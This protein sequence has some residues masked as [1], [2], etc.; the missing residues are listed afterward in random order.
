LHENVQSI[1]AISDVLIS[2]EQNDQTLEHQQLIVL[3]DKCQEIYHQ[4][5]QAEK[6]RS[7]K[8]ISMT[9]GEIDLF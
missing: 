9:E 3:K 2:F 4:T 5:K 1:R 6:E 7:V 8:Q